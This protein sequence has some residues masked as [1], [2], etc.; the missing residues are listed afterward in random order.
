M[1]L[2]HNDKADA[3]I[4]F[5]M[6]VDMVLKALGDQLERVQTLCDISSNS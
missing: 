3:E 4:A 2:F 1:Q 5:S 6:I